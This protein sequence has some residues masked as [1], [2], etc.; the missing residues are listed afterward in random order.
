MA[1]KEMTNGYNGEGRVHMEREILFLNNDETNAQAVKKALEPM[2]YKVSC[3]SGLPSIFRDMKDGS[4]LILLDVVPPEGDEIKA[5]KEIMT[6]HSEATVIMMTPHEEI[7]SKAMKEGAHDYIE[8]PFDVSEL[9]STVRRAFMDMEMRGKLHRP[10]GAE[11]DTRKPV[12]A[13]K[14]GKKGVE[15]IEKRDLF[16]EKSGPCSVKEF[17][18]ERLKRYL[19][20]MTNLERANLYDSVISEVEKAIISIVLDETGGNQLKAAKTLGINR[21]T[22]RAKVKKYGMS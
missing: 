8:K 10:R 22:L 1:L 12:T 7:G 4:Q 15:R 20:E 13:V 14:G 19:R 18:E 16:P 3:R 2:G 17:L 9:K 5:L 11:P 21:N 6:F